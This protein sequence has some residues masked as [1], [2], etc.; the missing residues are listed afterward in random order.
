MI[1]NFSML[2][3]HFTHPYLTQFCNVGPKVQSL[4]GSM[5]KWMC[6]YICTVRLS[7]DGGSITAA[8]CRASRK[9]QSCYSLASVQI[10]GLA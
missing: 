10:I 1:F 9:A 4:V 5:V 7:C 8:I 2:G 3:T 6:L